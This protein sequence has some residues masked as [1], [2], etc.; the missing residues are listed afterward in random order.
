LQIHGDAL[1]L[2]ATPGA[3]FGQAQWAE[4]DNVI[5]DELMEFFGQGLRPKAAD[6]KRLVADFKAGKFQYKFSSGNDDDANKDDGDLP[7]WG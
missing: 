7:G 6:I 4:L 1:V 5:Y 3:D 2:Y